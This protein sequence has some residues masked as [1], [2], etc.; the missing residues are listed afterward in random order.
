MPEYETLMTGHHPT[1]LR[2]A[3]RLLG[4]IEDAKD[5]AQEVSQVAAEPVCKLPGRRTVAVSGH[6]QLNILI[7]KSCRK[8]PC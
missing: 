3:Y 6:Y 8:V 5:A 7:G 4:Q 2:T 1:V